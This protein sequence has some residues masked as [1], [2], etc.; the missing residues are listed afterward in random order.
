MSPSEP[1]SAQPNSASA[2]PS[3]SAAWFGNLDQA[4]FDAAFYERILERQP[5]NIRVLK[6]LGELHARQGRHDR[7]IAI[8]RQLAKLLPEDCLVHYNLACSLAV[9]G[10]PQT[11]IE[12]LASALELGYNDFSHLEVDPDLK[13]LC[14]LPEFHSLL[15]NYGID[16]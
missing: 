8:D 16:G 6:L 2:F 11:A 9:Q 7:A 12:A 15:R 4:D 10:E 3:A 5:N 13:S 1:S 14:P